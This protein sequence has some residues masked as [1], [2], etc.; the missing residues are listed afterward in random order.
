METLDLYKILQL[1]KTASK[2]E[3]R[4]AYRKLVLKYHPD[5][6]KADGAAEMFRAVQIAYDTLSDEQKRHNYDRLDNWNHSV[7]LKDVFFTYQELIIEMCAK[8]QLSLEL[9]DELISLFNPEDFT[10]EIEQQNINAI[11]NKLIDKIWSH[12]KKYMARKITQNNYYLTSIM[13]FIIKRL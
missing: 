8:Y 10:K 4:V 1:D 6:N 9:K 7:E 11:H 12:G 2:E 13:E 3:I 5:K